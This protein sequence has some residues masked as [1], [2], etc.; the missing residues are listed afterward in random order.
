MIEVTKQ[1]K[2]PDTLVGICGRCKCHVRCM[3]ADA[4]QTAFGYRVKCPTQG[5]YHTIKLFNP[6]EG[7]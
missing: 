3:P 5:C 4:E 6:R 1:G 2:V 7:A